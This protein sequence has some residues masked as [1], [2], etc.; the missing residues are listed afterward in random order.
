MP[1]TVV[2]GWMNEWLKEVGMN[3][4]KKNESHSFLRSGRG[5]TWRHKCQHPGVPG[6]IQKVFDHGNDEHLRNNHVTIPALA[7]R[8]TM[9]QRALPSWHVLNFTHHDPSR[10]NLHS[11]VY[12]PSEIEYCGY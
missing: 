6:T 7:G 9:L 2:S 12:Q 1:T 11:L 8:R 3:E 5:N 4:W 10:H